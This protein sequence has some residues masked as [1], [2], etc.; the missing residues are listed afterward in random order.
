MIFDYDPRLERETVSSESSSY[1]LLKD[2]L[3]E[4]I[5]D[6]MSNGTASNYITNSYGSNHRILYEGV[7]SLIADLI[8][9]SADG[10]EDNEYSQLRAEYVSTRLLYSVFPDEDSVPTSQNVGEVIN[11]LL[12]TYE[13]LLEGATKKS[14]DEA[15]NDIFNRSTVTTEVENYIANITTSILATTEFNTDGI[16]SEHKHHAFTK[17]AGY[18]STLKPIGYR[19]G[20]DLHTHEIIDGEIQ[21]HTDADGVSHTHEIYFGLPENVM[22]LQSNLRKIFEVIKPSHIK[23]GEIT[24]ILEEPSS[25]SPTIE[26]EINGLDSVFLGLGSIYQEDMRKGRNGVWEDELYGYVSGKE[27]RFWR[28]PLNVADNVV[29][30]WEEIDPNTQQTIVK[31]QKLRVISTFEESPANQTA[32]NQ[33]ETLSFVREVASASNYA[34]QVRIQSG[35]LL[36]PGQGEVGLINLSFA[37]DG[38]P[39]LYSGDSKVYYPT[40]TGYEG[41][42][43]QPATKPYGDR[44]RLSSFVVRVDA[45]IQTEGIT[46]FKLV[47]LP[48]S[49]RKTREYSI[50]TYI[51]DGVDSFVLDL[52]SYI[53][54]LLQKNHR[55]LP[56]IGSDLEIKLNGVSLQ[57]P[58][59]LDLR[60]NQ[61]I[62]QLPVFSLGQEITLTYPSV[63]SSV[64]SFRELNNTNLLLNSIRPVRK[65]SLSGRGGDSKRASRPSFTSYV[66]NQA[67]PVR[68]LTLSERKISYSVS[69]SDIL[70]TFNQSLNSSF[71]LNRGSF[72]LNLSQD[73]VFAPAVKTITLTSGEVAFSQ[74]GY[75]PSFI[76][77]VEDDLGN[78]YDFTLSSSKLDI[79]GISSFPISLT[80]HAVSSSPLNLNQTWHKGDTLVEGQAF[81]GL[82]DT[83]TLPFLIENTPEEIIQNPL[84]LGTDE[85][86]RNILSS[87]KVDESGEYGELTFYEDSAVE[88]EIDGTD[89]FA[90][91][92]NPIQYQDTLLYQDPT[93]YIL[94]PRV[95]V[96]SNLVNTIPTYLFF[97]YFFLNTFGGNGHYFSI[98]RVGADGVKYYQTLTLIADSGGFLALEEYP[99]LPAPNGSP[100]AYRF[101]DDGNGG[102]FNVNYT[103]GEFADNYTAEINASF[104][105]IPNQTYFI[106]LYMEEDG[107]GAD[108]L[109]FFS[110][111]TN[112]PFVLGQD[113]LSSPETYRLDDANGGGFGAEY[114]YEVLFAT[115][116]GEV[117]SFDPSTDEFPAYSKESEEVGLTHEVGVPSYYGENLY[118]VA[119]SSFD[120]NTNFIPR[121][122]DGSIQY[123]FG[124][125]DELLVSTDEVIARF[126]F[127]SNIPILTDS[128]SLTYY[129][130]PSDIEEIL[131]NTEDIVDVTY[132]YQSPQVEDTL[133][134]SADVDYFYDLGDVIEEDNLRFED[135]VSTVYRFNPIN[136]ES[137]INAF[138]DD[139]SARI[140]SLHLEDS[141][142][143][144]SEP[145]IASYSLVPVSEESLVKDLS[146]DVLTTF[147]YSGVSESDSLTYEDSVST[148]IRSLFVSDSLS[149]DADA[150]RDISLDPIEVESE[151]VKLGS[152][153]TTQYSYAAVNEESL[154]VYLNDTVSFQMGV[155]QVDTLSYSDDVSHVYNLGGSSVE[156]DLDITDAVS[157]R[158]KIS[159]TDNAPIVDAYPNTSFLFSASATESLTYE[160]SVS[161]IHNRTV[162]VEGSLSSSDAVSTIETP[163]GISVA[164]SLSMSD[165]ATTSIGTISVPS[166]AVGVKYNNFAQAD[167]E[168]FSVYIGEMDTLVY[169]EV[170]VYQPDSQ[171][172]SP[173]S[174]LEG[175]KEIK[176][177]ASS[178]DAYANTNDDALLRFGPL[179][180]DTD[181]T[182]YSHTS[183]LDT[184]PDISA[185]FR[186]SSS[187]LNP[188]GFMSGKG[189]T[190]LMP[191][192][193][194]GAQRYF[195]HSFYIRSSDDAVIF[196]ADTG[197]DFTFDDL[198]QIR[199]YLHF[200]Y[201]YSTGDSAD[202]FAIRQ[203]PNGATFAS[204]DGSPASTGGW[205]EPTV[206]SDVVNHKT[207]GVYDYTDLPD[208]SVANTDND[209]Q[210]SWDLVIGTRY[211]LKVSSVDNASD[212]QVFLDP[213]TEDNGTSWNTEY[214]SSS[215]LTYTETLTNNDSQSYTFNHFF[216]IRR[217][218]FI[219]WEQDPS[220]S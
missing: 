18:G 152:E 177:L 80:I 149:F 195:R 213:R 33:G 157:Y 119:Y 194:D 1:R 32:F 97:N 76:T 91:D 48:W 108:T 121:N 173:I 85:G 172:L 176:V 123:F 64:K 110:S 87:R 210:V 41:E 170:T 180:Y 124:V 135:V 53:P 133:S 52:P 158:Y 21:P 81:V 215:S 181:Y 6:S 163:S 103:N 198:E 61:A 205:I 29:A 57:T 7:A 86:D 84:G 144:R 8:L 107:G 162:S 39:L 9:K 145:I 179:Q 211:H 70:N 2:I 216:T 146:D 13:A 204:P 47:S 202:N 67:S 199:L 112:Q 62:S 137:S 77:L 31:T 56:I 219:I 34:E 14:I 155:S 74:L 169:P 115:N 189:Y 99:N 117:V 17:S 129:L 27:I 89:G 178:S 113:W 134:Y 60:T 130:Y 90:N 148:G 136:E 79:K 37:D 140:S 159:L 190:D 50:D 131:A 122:A 68:P 139:L 183:Y 208:S 100:L 65:V 187:A 66:L 206:H 188:D 10:I 142:D 82:K 143:T 51:N 184:T 167:D 19:W 174:L 54:E 3:T 217:D 150:S 164:D 154:V 141:F 93:L 72:T 220:G 101:R 200:I 120:Q 109:H 75:I 128:I 168:M 71:V 55:N 15:L 40:I 16:V 126:S 156:S 88:Y 161:T 35:S 83:S 104:N 182:L 45:N 63:Q 185:A 5:V 36:P 28:H 138:G 105:H 106:E 73:Q 212:F 96:E 12:Q 175:S 166:L 69:T 30:I 20:D 58:F 42:E 49:V 192:S 114:Y 4:Q 94:G 78:S 26:D 23:T 92:Y 207:N 201:T 116:P 125:E 22:L 196:T 218:G 209:A 214:T 186:A 160:D 171:D 191:G 24:S 11:M 203:A 102:G 193:T 44:V 147:A 95:E 127:N 151:I 111:G 98:Y 197:T 165:T 38:E 43:V 46:L 25:L 132:R 118:P 59:F 153:I